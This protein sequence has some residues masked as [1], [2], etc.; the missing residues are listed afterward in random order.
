MATREGKKVFQS[1]GQLL[2]IILK[3]YVFNII[4]Q[5]QVNKI[6]EPDSFLTDFSKK[7]G[8]YRNHP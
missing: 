3:D 6:P 5:W 1:I 8:N 4:S 7:C 2:M